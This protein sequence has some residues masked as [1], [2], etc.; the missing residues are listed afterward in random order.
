MTGVW[1]HQMHERP[2]GT[3]NDGD[4][5]Q[6]VVYGGPP[7]ETG[8]V[9]TGSVVRS[10]DLCALTYDNFRCVNPDGQA[11]TMIGVLHFVE[12]DELRGVVTFVYETNQPCT[13]TYDVTVT[14]Q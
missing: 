14:M 6:A 9:C 7:R 2:N 8:V 5:E 3:C 13:A 12:A 4:F 10:A 1:L 11:A